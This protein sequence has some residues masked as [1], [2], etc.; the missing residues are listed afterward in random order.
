MLY[1]LKYH[2]LFFFL[3]LFLGIYPLSTASNSTFNPQE[4]TPQTALL[5]IDIQNFYFPGGR[6]PLMN[7]EDA[8]LNARTL[9]KLFREKKLLVIHIRHN[10]Q[11]GSE[12]HENVKPLKTEKVIS[13]N[14]VNCFKDTELLDYL[15]EHG[16]KRLV[17][18]GMMTHMCVEAAVRAAHDFGFECL[19][20]QDACATRALKYKDREIPAEAVYYSTLA[21]LSGYYAK[22]TD[23]ETFLKELLN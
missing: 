11:S 13:K 2:S 4:N 23:T 6:I 15:K 19:V 17:I 3:S 14:D 1:K 8:S 21:T 20:V 5:L 7:P 10:A 22:V 16:V 12:I 9:L 18:C